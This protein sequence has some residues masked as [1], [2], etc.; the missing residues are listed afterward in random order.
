MQDISNFRGDFLQGERIHWVVY[1]SSP[2]SFLNVFLFVGLTTLGTFIEFLLVSLLSVQMFKPLIVIYRRGYFVFHFNI[3]DVQQ[4]N[5]PLN[6]C[7]CTCM[8][9][10]GGGGLDLAGVCTC[11]PPGG[12]GGLDLAGDRL[13]RFSTISS[14]ARTVSISS[15]IKLFIVPI[16]NCVAV[17]SAAGKWE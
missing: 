14:S 15:L 16:K 4:L 9:P 13:S 17:Y 5:G 10:G 2:Q 6:P 8:P 11:M 1:Y 7:K 3:G 12:G